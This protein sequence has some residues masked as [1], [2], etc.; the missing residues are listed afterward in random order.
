MSGKYHP[1][2]SCLALFEFVRR[3]GHIEKLQKKKKKHFIE[4]GMEKDYS[5]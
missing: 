3:M 2:C 5:S 4:K 1:D